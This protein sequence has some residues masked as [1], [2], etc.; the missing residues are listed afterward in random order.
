MSFLFSPILFV[1]L[2]FI[3]IIGIYN[4]LQY[5]AVL[6]ALSPY[7]AYMYFADN[8]FRGWATLGSVRARR[9]RGPAPDRRAAARL[10]RAPGGAVP[11]R[12]R[13]AV[14]RHGPLFAHGHP[15][16][17]VRRGLPRG[18]AV[19]RRTERDSVHAA[20][21]PPRRRGGPVPTPRA[22]ARQELFSN[23][24]YTT[25]PSTAFIPMLVLTTLATIIAS[26]VRPARPARPAREARRA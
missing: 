16:Q 10:G 19:V 8:G 5:P 1:W 2:V 13:G 21:A 4:I 23:P 3:A 24:F 20:G 17:L 11:D 22:R 18:A 7:Y 12:R 15:A 14:C 26:Q 25:M 6:A 9:W